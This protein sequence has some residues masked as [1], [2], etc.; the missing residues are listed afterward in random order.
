MKQKGEKEELK[1]CVHGQRE[2]GTYFIATALHTSTQTCLA[3]A[4]TLPNVI[5]LFCIALYLPQQFPNSAGSSWYHCSQAETQRTR[6]R[7]RCR[8]TCHLHSHELFAWHLKHPS[9]CIIHDLEISSFTRR[10]PHHL[11]FMDRGRGRHSLGSISKS[12][13]CQRKGKRGHLRYAGKSRGNRYLS[14]L[15]YLTL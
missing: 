6:V 1:P 14:N 11:H 8:N 7:P 2:S 15:I 12:G 4:H 9:L 10:P 13:T 5:P 3:H